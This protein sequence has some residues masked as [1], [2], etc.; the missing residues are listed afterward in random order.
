[1]A[2]VSEQEELVRT[3]YG[4]A[5]TESPISIRTR[6]HGQFVNVHDLRA[7]LY[8]DASFCNDQTAKTYILDLAE[9]LGR[10]TG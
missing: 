1:V 5:R 4:R 10:L 8:R 7:Q 6:F 3:A 2:E 9:R